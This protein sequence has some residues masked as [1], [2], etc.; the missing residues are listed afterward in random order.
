MKAIIL[1]AGQGTRLRP[2]TDN[3]PKALLAINNTTLLERHLRSF[4]RVG[5]DDIII[6][7]GFKKELIVEHVN[8]KKY[9]MKISF[10]E[11]E[12]FDKTKSSYSLW[13]ALQQSGDDDVLFM[14]A[15]LYYEPKLFDYIRG[16]GDGNHILVGGTETDDEAVKVMGEKGIM[17]EIGK[18]VSA[19]Y[20][21][22]GEAVGIIKFDNLGRTILQDNLKSEIDKGNLE[23]D[24]DENLNRIT[25]KIPIAIVDAGQTKWTEIDFH[26]DYQKA[27]SMYNELTGNNLSGN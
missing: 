13:L 4:H 2:I 11:N 9:K 1:A 15:D 25:N 22:Y 16:F 17:K 6:V 23:L 21:C 27:K 5:I 26:E 18:A 24:W 14:D 10:V 12:D 20:H 19:R 8:K 7:V 3:L